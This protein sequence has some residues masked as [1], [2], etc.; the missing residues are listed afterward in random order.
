MLATHYHCE[1]YREIYLWKYTSKSLHTWRSLAKNCKNATILTKLYVYIDGITF[2]LT[3]IKAEPINHAVLYGPTAVRNSIGMGVQ[4]HQRQDSWNEE[5]GKN[6][7]WREC[8]RSMD[9]TDDPHLE[10]SFGELCFTH[11]FSYTLFTPVTIIW[12]FPI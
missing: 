9:A 4:L 3:P 1:S 8:F 2:A 11:L 6:R 5:Q 10:V 12:T 7:V